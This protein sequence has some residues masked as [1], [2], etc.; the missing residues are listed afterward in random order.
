MKKQRNRFISNVLVALCLTLAVG[1]SSQPSPQAKVVDTATPNPPTPT[2]TLKPTETFTS[3]PSPTPLLMP[4][5]QGYHPMAYD[6][7][8]DRLILVPRQ[9]NNLKSIS[10]QT[11]T[12]DLNTKTWQKSDGPANGEGPMAYDAQSDRT[13]LFL[14]AVFKSSDFSFKSVGITLAYDAN[15][16]TWTDMKPAESPSGIL[17]ARMVYDSESDRII[18]FGGLRVEDFTETSDTWAYDYETNTWVN[19]QPKGNP[20]L[21]SGENFFA[22]SYD[23]GA[24]RVVAWKCTLTLSENKIGIYDYN[25]NTWE[26]RDT[27]THPNYCVYNSMV[28]DPGTGLNILFGGVTGSEKPSN[29]TWGYDYASNSWKNLEAKNPPSARGWHA[30]VYDSKAMVMVLFGGGTSRDEFTNELWTY[31]SNANEWSQVM[32]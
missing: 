32:P 26:E 29:E 17:G 31:D 4:S 22:M 2:P 30:M 16:D 8:S 7:K 21:P 15:T 20:P 18:L 24:D 25:S 28:Y 6:S 3:E 13:I 12:F 5:P 27:E 9:G 10:S 11:W 23:A 14:G 1:C 19:L